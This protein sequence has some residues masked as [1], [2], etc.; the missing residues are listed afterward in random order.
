MATYSNIFIDQGSTYTS[1]IEVK[2]NN[3]LL[4]DLTDYSSRGQI[5][6]TY[7]SSTSVSFTTSIDLPLEGK[8]NLSLTATQTRAMKQGRYV[9]DV[10]IYNDDGNVIRVCEGQLEITPAVSQP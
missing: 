8:I 1:V 7:T 10:E 6:K 9:Y 3:G 4:Y 5:R 2:D